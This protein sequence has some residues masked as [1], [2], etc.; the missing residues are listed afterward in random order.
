MCPPTKCCCCEL[1]SG[2]KAWAIVFI[3]LSSISVAFTCFSMWFVSAL[4]S[5]EISSWESNAFETC[6]YV[7]CKEGDTFDWDAMTGCDRGSDVCTGAC[8]SSIH[9]ACTPRTVH[10]A[11]R[12]HPNML[13]G[14]SPCVRLASR[15]AD[16]ARDCCAHDDWGEPKTCAVRRRRA[17]APRCW[18]G[19]AAGSSIAAQR[20]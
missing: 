4:C 19:R 8:L 18:Q 2:V 14:C 3:V 11:V 20:C 16:S 9:S 15:P 13:R 5:G 12:A 7:C 6:S 10:L 1:E 17:I